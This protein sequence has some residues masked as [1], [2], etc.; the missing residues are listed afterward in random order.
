M[1]R[2]SAKTATSRRQFLRKAALV[3]LGAAAAPHVVSASAGGAG[4][5]AAPSNRIAMGCIGVGRMGTA[6]LRSFLGQ[7]DVRMA[8]VCDVRESARQIAKA[9]VDAFYGDTACAAY[10]D[11]RELLARPDIDAVVMAVPDHWHALVGLEA[12]RRGKDIY[13]EKPMGLSVAEG[14]AVRE[15]VR[16]HGVVFQFGTQQRSNQTYRL[17]C[18]LVRNGRIGSVHTVMVGSAVAAAGP[19]APPEPVPPGFDYDLWLGPAPW[20]PY[21]A[22]RCSPAWLTIHDYC[23]GCIG[24]AWGVHDMDIVQWALG[25]EDTGPVEVE[26]AGIIPRDGLCDVPITWEVQHRY[27]SGVRLI[28]MDMRTALRRA[29][30]FELAWMGALFQ[31][32]AGWVY[33]SRRGFFTHPEGLARESARPGEVRLAVSQDHRRNF[34]DAVKG[35]ADPMAS[36]ESAVR[37]DTL[38]HQADVAIRLGRRLRW[39][40]AGEVFVGDEEANRVLRRPMRSPWR[41]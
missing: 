25:T 32:T 5:G 19:N 12:A 31:G 28:H 16:R 13:Y 11:F 23:L 36:V 30:Q 41:L 24:G 6:H 8:A 3:V 22:A 7:E 20:A 27:A 35:R 2:A 26:G 9:L 1:M 4:G 34:L 18:E 14:Q 37:S 38:C 21:A 40:P 33:V 17:A 15:A 29:K 39:D 10:N